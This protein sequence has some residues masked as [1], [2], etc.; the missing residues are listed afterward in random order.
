VD[1]ADHG[2]GWAMITPS[3]RLPDLGAWLCRYNDAV[4]S[5]LAA[6]AGWRRQGHGYAGHQFVETTLRCRGESSDST[7]QVRTS[8]TND[9]AAPPACP[10]TR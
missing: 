9:R 5:S 1:A 2:R 4:G 10:V 6:P 8:V 3:G 7:E